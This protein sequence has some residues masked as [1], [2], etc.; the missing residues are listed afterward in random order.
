[1]IVCVAFLGFPDSH[2]GVE[3]KIEGLLGAALTKRR[4]MG[5]KIGAQHFTNLENQ[6][7]QGF[8]MSVKSMFEAT[9]SASIR[10][11]LR[12]FLE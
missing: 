5:I 8:S 6:E 10:K 1:M 3:E 4:S 2:V 12:T 7:H 9:S 11:Y